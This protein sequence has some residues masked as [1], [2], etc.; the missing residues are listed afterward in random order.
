MGISR[1]WSKM[2]Q[3][4]GEVQ[5]Q[6]VIKR[7]MGWGMDGSVWRRL[8]RQPEKLEGHRCT[9][10]ETERE[11]RVK[12]GTEKQGAPE[13]EIHLPY[14]MFLRGR[15]TLQF[16]NVSSWLMIFFHSKHFCLWNKI[17]T[18]SKRTL[19]INCLIGEELRLRDIKWFAKVTQLCKSGTDQLW[20]G[21]V[22]FLLL[23]TKYHSLAPLKQHMFI[24]HSFCRSG[25]WQPLCRVL[26]IL[27]CV[28]LCPFPRPQTEVV[29]VMLLAPCHIPFSCSSAEGALW[30]LRKESVHV[31]LR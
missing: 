2:G 31:V 19:E 29:V 22:C 10:P 12:K 8:G 6:V 25:N 17:F 21:D 11:Q 26:T 27:A 16:S 5:S 14:N 28:F 20:L 13:K 3:G 23:C 30:K 18:E 15:L 4:R 9:R 1:I 24:S 7:E